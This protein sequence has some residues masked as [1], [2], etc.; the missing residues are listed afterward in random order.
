MRMINLAYRYFTLNLRC[1][2]PARQ[3]VA[4]K[5]VELVRPSNEFQKTTKVEN[6]CNPDVLQHV[7]GLVGRPRLKV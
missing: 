2:A 5:Y 7:P 1:N 3:L 4:I 6:L